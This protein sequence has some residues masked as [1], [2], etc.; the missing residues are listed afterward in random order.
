MHLDYWNK[1]RKKIDSVG[2]LFSL[3]NVLA[4]SRVHQIFFFCRS[5]RNVVLLDVGYLGS[6]IM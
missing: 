4:L 6:L 2:S 3:G 5:V 1:F